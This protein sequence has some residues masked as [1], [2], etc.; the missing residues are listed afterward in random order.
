ME[1]IAESIRPFVPQFEIYQPYLVK[2]ADVSSLIAKLVEDEG[3]DFGEFIVIQEAKPECQGW[4]FHSFLNEPVN[5]LASY[6]HF[7]S[8]RL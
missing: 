1:H 5:R 7:F 8:V 2:L 4:N 6:P 3:S